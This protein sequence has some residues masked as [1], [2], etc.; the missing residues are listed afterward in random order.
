MRH[1]DAST[2]IRELTKIREEQGLTQYELGRRIGARSDLIC[3]WERLHV[4]PGMN[5]FFRWAEALGYEFDLFKT[6]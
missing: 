5:S 4:A 6:Q 1:S 2:L 3:K